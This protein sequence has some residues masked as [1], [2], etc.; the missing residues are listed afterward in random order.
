[1]T[2]KLLL[3][4][5]N[6]HKRERVRAFLSEAW[7]DWEVIEA[8]SFTSACKKISETDVVFD[9]VLL[10]VSLPTYDKLGSESGGRF[11]TLGGSEV[12]RKLVKKNP[13]TKILFLTQYEA[14][15]ERGNSHTLESLDQKLKLEC[16]A[17]YLGLVHYD[18]SRS[19]WKARISDAL[20]GLT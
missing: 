19:A 11:R 12:A 13:D 5:D 17:S 1:M 4:E 2:T 10:D 15:S 3:V 14:F 16:A 18:S 6:Q 9:L 7:P 8:K 20:R